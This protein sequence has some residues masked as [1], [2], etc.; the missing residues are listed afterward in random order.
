MVWKVDGIVRKTPSS[1][2]ADI[3]DLD[4]NS[5]TSKI[6]G[7]LIDS[8]VAQGMLKLNL[9]WDDCTEAEAEE[10]MQLSFRNPLIATFKIPCV[11]GGILENAKFRVSK[12]KCSMVDTEQ[13]ETTTGTHYSVSY[14]LMQ[15][16][17]TEQQGG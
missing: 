12:R 10:L 7:A 3:E 8:V 4:N 2:D 16:E 6:T 14:N 13:G 9:K 15:K 1:Y 5:Y 11:Q 17:L